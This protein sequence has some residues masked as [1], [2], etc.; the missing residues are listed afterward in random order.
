MYQQYLFICKVLNY[1]CCFIFYL[2]IFCSENKIKWIDYCYCLWDHF[3][4]SMSCHGDFELTFLFLVFCSKLF[5][6]KK[7]NWWD[8]MIWHAH[9]CCYNHGIRNFLFNYFFVKLKVEFWRYELS[10]IRS[11]TNNPSF[12][13]GSFNA[14][15]G[16]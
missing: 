4:R 13:D 2:L 16:M 14:R 11:V 8:W 12:N 7:N 1:T 5:R 15:F 10:Q 6:V 3:F 9:A